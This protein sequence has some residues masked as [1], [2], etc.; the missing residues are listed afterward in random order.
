MKKACLHILTTVIITI[1]TELV[2]YQMAKHF[3]KD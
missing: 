3:K 2:T 1:L